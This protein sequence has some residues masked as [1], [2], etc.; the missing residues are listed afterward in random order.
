MGIGVHEASVENL[1]SKGFKEL[2]I[3]VL[4]A[5]LF[6]FYRLKI[7]NLTALHPL[8]SKNALKETFFKLINIV[9]KI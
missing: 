8:K 7:V 6:F 3:D 1:L 4:Q 9:Y 2:Y 5:E